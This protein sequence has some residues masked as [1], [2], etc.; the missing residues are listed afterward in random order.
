MS[1]PHKERWYRRLAHKLGYD[2]VKFNKQITVETHLRALLPVLKVD[3][4]LDVGANEGQYAQALRYVGYT[5]DIMSFEPAAAAYA[6]LSQRAQADPR[7]QTFNLA[8]SDTQGSAELHQSAASVFN[9]LHA[10]SEFGRQKF[11]ASIT[12]DTTETISLNRFDEFAAQH[13]PDLAKRRVFLKMDTQG[14]DLAVMRG[15]GDWA[16][17]FCGLQ[18]EVAVMPIYEG[19]PDYMQA[20]S[21]YRALG[22]EV[23]GLFTVSRNRASGHVVEFDCVMAPPAQVSGNLQPQ[24]SEG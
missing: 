23:T 9:S 2:L 1:S 22:Y 21:E 16:T 24:L 13:L 19:I 18:S 10:T 4:V 12:A 3:L 5:G 7:W 11:G 15:C 20:I 6:R 14:H 17:R 8:L